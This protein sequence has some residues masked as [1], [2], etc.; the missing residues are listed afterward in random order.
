M[1]IC[2]APVVGAARVRLDVKSFLAKL[3]RKRVPAPARPA[4]PLAP[5]AVAPRPSAA[6]AKSPGD[7]YAERVE[8][9]FLSTARLLLPRAAPA[10]KKSAAET[11]L[12]SLEAENQ[13][14]RAE[15][16]RLAGEIV[17]LRT[18]MFLRTKRRPA[19]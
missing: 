19:P 7:S 6:P 4:A 13:F 3:Q 18:L 5:A 8:D 14:L 16:E 2:R 1:G 11:R 17:S 12:A 9:W 15:N 10:A